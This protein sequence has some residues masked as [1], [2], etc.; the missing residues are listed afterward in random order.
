MPN[1]SETSRGGGLAIYINSRKFN[2]DSTKILHNISSAISPE[3]GEF[4]FV[5]IDTGPKNK[6]IIIGNLYRSP[7]FK[8]DSFT[9]KL[10]EILMGDV[11]IDLIQHGSN[12]HV[13]SYFNMVSQKGFIPV[14]S[15]PTRITEHSMTLIDHIFSNSMSNFLKSDILKYPFA[16]H[17]GVFI[18]ISLT[19]TL[20]HTNNGKYFY[21]EISDKTNNNFEKLI[22]N[23][24]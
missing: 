14:I 12:V 22:Y 10:S 16:D 8:P 19:N 21:T 1:F 17:L 7:S 18:K 5:E 4:L 15:R 11:N 20:T 13:Q 23:A 3:N 2:E 6:N 9:E 24:D